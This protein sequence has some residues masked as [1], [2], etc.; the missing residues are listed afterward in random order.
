M[1]RGVPMTHDRELGNVMQVLDK[2]PA[3]YRGH[4][5]IEQPTHPRHPHEPFTMRVAEQ[6]EAERRRERAP[7]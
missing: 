5:A 2:G 7:P 3:A 1:M 6:R 4:D